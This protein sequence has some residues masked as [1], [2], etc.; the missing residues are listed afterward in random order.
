MVCLSAIYTADFG[1]LFKRNIRRSLN[2]ND[3]NNSLLKN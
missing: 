2:N 1:A 3:S